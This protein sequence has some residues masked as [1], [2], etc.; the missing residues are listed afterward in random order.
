[1]T[2][3]HIR[4][5][6]PQDIA[7]IYEICRR[8]AAAGKDGTAQFSDPDLPGLL[9]AGA[10]PVLEPDCAFVLDIGGQAAGYVIGTPDTAAFEARME[11]EWWPQV[12]ARVAQME[13]GAAEKDAMALERIAAP[14]RQMPEILAR[15]PAHLHINLLPEAQGGGW[16]RRLIETQLAHMRDQGAR[17]LHLGLD[18]LNTAAA[19]FYR[20]LGFS[21]VSR[22]G[23]VIYGMALGG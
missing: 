18:P 7:R 19:E 17:G 3:T 14:K 5:A 15:F 22:E 16:G 21:D 20:H 4:R 2:Q 11:A 13:L 9:F 12:R 6:R 10:Y 8:T 23:Q 1:M